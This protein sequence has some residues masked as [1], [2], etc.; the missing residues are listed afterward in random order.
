MYL[1]ILSSYSSHADVVHQDTSDVKV[2]MLNGAMYRMHRFRSTGSPIK[3]LTSDIMVSCS[4][5]L[6]VSAALIV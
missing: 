3:G 4:M 6:Y 5:T 1:D 2:Q